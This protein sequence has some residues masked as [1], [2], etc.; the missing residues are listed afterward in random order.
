MALITNNLQRYATG[1]LSA[2]WA[3]VDCESLFS[4]VVEKLEDLLKDTGSGIQHQPLP[5]I[6][7]INSLLSLVFQELLINA[8]NSR[9]ADRMEI[10]VEAYPQ[11]AGWVFLVADNGVGIDRRHWESIFQPFFTVDPRAWRP[12]LGLAFTRLAVG[13]LG[14][15][16]QVDASNPSGTVFQFFLPGSDAVG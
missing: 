11:D 9:A 1:L 14:G 2:D 4:E 13:H 8:V 3:V 7:S 5:R 10:R 15:K 12:G 16:I 6:F